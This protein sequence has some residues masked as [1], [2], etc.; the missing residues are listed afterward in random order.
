MAQAWVMGPLLGPEVGVSRIRTSE[1]VNHEG[2][3]TT[4]VLGRQTCFYN[5]DSAIH[6]RF[7]MVSLES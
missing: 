4:E 3:V 7:K 6:L 2:M 1:P 5:T